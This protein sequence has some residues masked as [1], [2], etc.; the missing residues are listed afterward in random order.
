MA[1]SRKTDRP[2][3]R[4]KKGIDEATRNG[5]ADTDTSSP[6]P[7]DEPKL[8]SSEHAGD[9]GMLG[10]YRVLKKVGIGGMGAVYLGFDE[11][12]D[13]KVALKV[14]LPKVAANAA[15][16]GRFLREARASAKVEHP[17]IV[18]VYSVGEHN[19]VPFLAMQYLEGAPLDKYLQKKSPTLSQILRV[20]RETAE[21]LAAAHARGL[22]HRDIK[23]ANLWLEAPHGHIKIL[24]FGLAK[25]SGEDGGTE[26]TQTGAVVGTPAYMAPEQARAQTVDARTDLYSLGAVLYRL[27]TGKQPFTGPNVMAVL[28]ALALDKPTPVQEL[29]PAIP[30]ALAD[31]IHKCLE[32]DAA[33]RPKSAAEVVSAIKAI[34]KGSATQ[35]VLPAAQREIPASAPESYSVPPSG[36]GLM[37]ITVE[38][39]SAFANLDDGDDVAASAKSATRSSAK[40]ATKQHGES[41]KKKLPVWVPIAGGAV[42]VAVTAIVAVMTLG[43]KVQGPAEE[44]V[45][46]GRRVEKPKAASVAPTGT[47]AP[48]RPLEKWIADFQAAKLEMQKRLLNDE[49]MKRN[50]RCIDD[51]VITDNGT[52]ITSVAIVTDMV[53]D[54]SPL[55]AVKGLTALSLKSRDPQNCELSDLS[56]LANLPID[57]L[58]LHGIATGDLTPLTKLPLKDLRISKIAVRDLAPLAGKQ[59]A[60][61]QISNCGLT[62]LAGIETATIDDFQCTSTP[63]SDLSPLAKCGLKRITFQAD[64]VKDLSPLAE[65]PLQAV[66]WEPVQARIDPNLL[67]PLRSLA[68]LTEIHKMPASEYWIL[69][70][71]RDKSSVSPIRDLPSTG[72]EAISVAISHDGKLLA[73][74]SKDGVIRIWS[75]SNFEPGV[76]IKPSGPVGRILFLP[77]TEL[78]AGLGDA[79]IQFWNVTSG[80]PAGEPIQSSVPLAGL[81]LSPNGK[82]LFA[83]TGPNPANDHQ[84]RTWNLPERTA[85]SPFAGFDKAVG[86]SR[87]SKDG[88]YAVVSGSNRRLAVFDLAAGKEIYRNSPLPPAQGFCVSAAFGNDGSTIL[89]GDEDGVLL[90]IDWKTKAEFPLGRLNMLTRA[91]L[92][93]AG[94][95][96]IAGSRD[97][98]ISIVDFTTG[99]IISQ[100]NGVSHVRGIAVSPDGKTVATTHQ[101]GHVRVWDYNTMI[102]RKAR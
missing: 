38:P 94:T 68:T 24:D 95:H 90:R 54:I 21:G 66:A 48:R 88:R 29:N 51:I 70:D 17:N 73:A 96:V 18:S 81:S 102:G 6:L 44:P 61:L 11:S 56:P 15:A 100:T 87:I 33:N 76:V 23:P 14:M 1:A 79:S 91:V 98:W 28:S 84:L 65:C 36:L 74:T 78:L 25:P 82:I 60:V 4:P 34:E 8:G 53:T 20:G 12:L 69:H 16:K 97:G 35:Q 13:R 63:V 46:Q 45:P 101:D 5:A 2:A 40:S 42:L 75:I 64:R 32:K 27:C 3:D 39:E 71:L 55:A 41:A 85:N 80:T 49:L 89:Y 67:L 47:E 22:I 19:G 92:N 43:G 86:Q 52:T 50:P 99:T 10:Q 7:T 62:T 30:Q 57:S 31:L 9:L 58:T 93:P 26:L 77:G 59:F 72:Q 37:N 83:G